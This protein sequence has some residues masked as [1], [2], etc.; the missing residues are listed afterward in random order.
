MSNIDDKAVVPAWAIKEPELT[1]AE[2]EVDDSVML[3][4]KKRLATA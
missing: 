3:G 1:R 4:T 2:C